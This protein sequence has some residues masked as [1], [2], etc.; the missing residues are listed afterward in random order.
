MIIPSNGSSHPVVNYTGV[1]LEGYLP[2]GHLH[3]LSILCRYDVIGSAFGRRRSEKL[4]VQRARLSLVQQRS[5][6]VRAASKTFNMPKERQTCTECSMRRQ[7]CDRQIPC[8]R[9]VKRGEGDKCTREWPEGGYDA[10]VHRSYPSREQRLTDLGQQASPKS[11]PTSLTNSGSQPS[12][13]GHARAP[14]PLPPN[15]MNTDVM[16]G[17]RNDIVNDSTTTID[18]ISWGKAKLSD[19]DLKPMQLSNDGAKDPL[20]MELTNC[21]SGI[22]AT[23]I[24][25]LQLLLPSK[26][27]IHQLVEY[28]MDS[29]LWYHSCFNGP[30]FYKELQDL[31][32]DSSDLH[33][34]KTDLRWTALLFSIMAGSLTVAP[35][36]TTASWGF[37]KGDRAKLT[38]QWFKATLTCLNLSDYMWRHHIYSI[39]AILVLIISG[40]ILGYS[41]T[42]TTLLGTALKI[43]QGLGFHKLSADDEEPRYTTGTG[44]V[45]MIHPSQR[46]RIIYRQRG[47]LAWLQLCNQDWFSVGFTE[48]YSIQRHHFTT[49]RP[50]NMNDQTL[51]EVPLDVPTSVSTLCHFNDLATVTAQMHD[52]KCLASTT[53]AQYDSVLKF[54][55]KIRAVASESIP[56]WL[57]SR[58]AIEPHWPVWVPWARRSFNLCVCHKIIMTHKGFLGRS[59]RNPAF[60]YSRDACLSAARS[61][62]KG[63]KQAYDEEGP[64]FWIDQAFM[65]TAG[66]VFALDFFHRREH[67]GEYAEHRKLLEST[68]NMLR[69]FENSA[70]GIRGARLLSTLLTERAKMHADSTLEMYKKHSLEN[71]ADDSNGKRVKFDVPKFVEQFIGE[72]SFTGSLRDP[73]KRQNGSESVHDSSGLFMA[74][75]RWEENQVS[76]PGLEKFEELFPPQLGMSNSFLFE[77]LLNFDL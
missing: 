32:T 28:H 8:S 72:S 65:V 53:L 14:V 34:Q 64:S 9:C 13:N 66:I 24:A 16:L 6:R 76:T 50:T 62:L 57:D 51:D 3:L 4:L 29:V 37:Q 43:A 74:Q 5:N 70:I 31:S 38:R 10:R 41:T 22:G 67:E 71:G 40:H 47:R 17:K 15:S 42:M 25:F 2:E 11:S 68:I 21:F 19:Y 7:K 20:E 58:E 46:E 52:A 61:I 59:F 45:P 75:P 73:A 26:R 1:S 54:D 56:A 55:A 63:A 49:T 60:N 48:M 77:D 36:S 39:E 30:T 18:F 23:Q 12:P 69:M 44:L 33:L 27:Q 35:A